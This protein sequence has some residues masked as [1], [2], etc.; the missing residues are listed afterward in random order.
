MSARAWLRLEFRVAM[1][2]EKAQQ[3]W[4]MEYVWVY[5]VWVFDSDS[6]SDYNKD[7]ASYTHGLQHGKI[8]E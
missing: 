4:Y 2:S 7:S 5:G 6:D 3:Q 1:M 8:T